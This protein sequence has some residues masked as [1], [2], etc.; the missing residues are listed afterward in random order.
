M[1]SLVS[2]V[3]WLEAKSV[4]FFDGKVWCLENGKCNEH[5]FCERLA[6]EWQH[7][8]ALPFPDILK[9]KTATAQ[10]RKVRQCATFI[11]MK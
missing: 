4:A 3:Y 1:S 11:N 10:A 2:S 9:H 7:I 8:S 6:K 5:C